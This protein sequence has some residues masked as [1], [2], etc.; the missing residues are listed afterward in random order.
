MDGM[1]RIFGTEVGATPTLVYGGYI[2]IVC[3][4]IHLYTQC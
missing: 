1:D 2:V 3:Y 4:C